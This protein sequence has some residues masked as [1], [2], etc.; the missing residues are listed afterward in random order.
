[1]ACMTQESTKNFIMTTN[2]GSG[3]SLCFWFWVFHHL[4]KNELSTALLCFPIQALVFGQAYR[5]GKISDPNSLVSYDK[6]SPP[7]A[8]TIKI[9]GKSISWTIWLGTTKDRIMKKHEKSEAFRNARI[10]ISTTDKAHWSL[11][12]E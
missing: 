9:N 8:G 12:S 4:T 10:R 6:E 11:M 3:K 5:L 7:Y 2:T 1:K